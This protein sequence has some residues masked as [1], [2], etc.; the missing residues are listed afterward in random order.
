MVL[1]GH[2]PYGAAKKIAK[3][4]RRGAHE[5]HEDR[6]GSGPAAPHKICSHGTSMKFQH[7][8]STGRGSLASAGYL[9][10][11]YFRYST[12]LP[13]VCTRGACSSSSARLCVQ[14]KVG[15]AHRRQK[16]LPATFPAE[17]SLAA[18]VALLAVALV[19]C[20]IVPQPSSFKKCFELRASPDLRQPRVESR[21]V[22]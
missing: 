5:S 4:P 13:A 21:E 11:P 18:G 3:Y 12:L 6:A 2:V 10:G 8:T 14:K 15:G 17:S 19:A 22:V 9:D 1:R 16:T 20:L 7:S